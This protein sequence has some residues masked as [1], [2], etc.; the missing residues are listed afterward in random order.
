MVGTSVRA[1][2]R[3]TRSCHRNSPYTSE[4]NGWN[5]DGFWHRGD[6][7]VSSFSETCQQI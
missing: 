4:R 5:E 3:L 2:P 7:Y 1:V 6:A